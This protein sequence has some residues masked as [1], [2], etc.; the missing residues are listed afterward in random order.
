MPSVILTPREVDLSLETGGKP[1]RNK[2]RLMPSDASDPLFQKL[3]GMA[4][5]GDSLV[6]TQDIPKV[7]GITVGSKLEVSASRIENDKRQC[8]RRI[9]AI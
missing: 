5:S 2:A 1:A 8:E 7:A 4:P 6:V 9:H 3:S